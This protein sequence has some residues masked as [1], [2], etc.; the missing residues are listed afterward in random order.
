MK[1]T[2]HL[3]TI[4]FTSSSRYIGARASAWKAIMLHCTFSCCTKTT[5]RKFH[6]IRLRIYILTWLMV[7]YTP[8]TFTAFHYYYFVLPQWKRIKT[9]EKMPRGT[10]RASRIFFALLLAHVRC[11]SFWTGNKFQTEKFRKMKTKNNET[12]KKS[13]EPA[14]NWIIKI[15]TRSPIVDV[16]RSRATN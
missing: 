12:E 11:A 13:E 6:S 16:R 4:G 8:K 10:E 15:D 2:F 5:T 1:W 7:I 14:F 9:T 3:Y